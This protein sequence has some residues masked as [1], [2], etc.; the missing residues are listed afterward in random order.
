MKFE[1]KF[2]LGDKVKYLDERNM[3]HIRGTIRSVTFKKL[4]EP[5][6]S[7]EPDN[8]KPQEWWSVPESELELL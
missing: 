7:I 2:S 4:I 3:H 6:Y 1:S 8:K 5:Y